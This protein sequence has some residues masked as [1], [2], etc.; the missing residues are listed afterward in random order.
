MNI[1]RD[2]RLS[3]CTLMAC[4]CYS[5]KHELDSKLLTGQ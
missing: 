4:Y 5:Y 1:Q 3:V 2:P